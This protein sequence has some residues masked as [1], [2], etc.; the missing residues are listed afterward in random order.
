MEWIKYLLKTPF[1]EDA[2][3]IVTAFRVYKIN[4]YQDLQNLPAKIGARI[5]AHD[6][7][8]VIAALNKVFAEE[9]ASDL[10]PIE[11]AV[12][13][14]AAK[15]PEA[16]IKTGQPKKAPVP[17]RTGE[18]A[19]QGA[20]DKVAEPAKK[21]EKAEPAKKADVADKAE[22]VKPADKVTGGKNDG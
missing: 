13:A 16:E 3:R 4:S 10:P 19:R 22:P 5:G 2:D 12:V 9:K 21:A 20:S 17:E 18:R 8:Q 11:E 14:S 15:E 7:Y 1:K 6:T